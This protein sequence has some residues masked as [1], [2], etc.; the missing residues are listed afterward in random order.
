MLYASFL[1]LFFNRGQRVQSNLG[2]Q[3]VNRKCRESKSQRISKWQQ[4][5]RAATREKTNSLQGMAGEF[6]LKKII[7]IFSQ[8]KNIYI[9]DQKSGQIIKIDGAVWTPWHFLQFCPLQ[10]CSIC[11]C[12]TVRK[13]C[14]V[15][16]DTDFFSVTTLMPS[17][18]YLCRRLC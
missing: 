5:T 7:N 15:T 11:F 3:L 18:E 17:N 9:L 13:P 16:W 6:L 14:Q 1:F 8:E 12:H 4:G 10:L 2:W